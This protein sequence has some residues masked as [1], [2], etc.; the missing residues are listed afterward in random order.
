MDL[1]IPKQGETQASP[2]SHTL[3][4]G[5]FKDRERSESAGQRGIIRLASISA[6]LWLSVAAETEIKQETHT[7]SQEV[8]TWRISRAHNKTMEKGSQRWELFQCAPP[9][10]KFRGS[11]VAPQ[12]EEQAC[13]TQPG[14]PVNYTHLQ[15]PKTK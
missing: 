12:L 8:W 1:R 2:H 13:H 10:L 9:S 5:D 11:T 15:L 4:S 7:G 3:S 6:I 14:G